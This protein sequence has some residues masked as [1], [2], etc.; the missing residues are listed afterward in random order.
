LCRCEACVEEVRDQVAI[1]PMGEREQLLDDAVRI[2]HEQHQRRRCSALRG[3]F[4]GGAAMVRAYPSRPPAIVVR[5]TQGSKIGRT[6]QFLRRTHGG[7]AALW[8]KF[9]TVTG[10]G[11]G[12]ALGLTGGHSALNQQGA[13]ESDSIIDALVRSAA[14]IRRRNSRC[15]CSNLQH[16]TDIQ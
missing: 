1:A 9:A 12:G 10:R 6:V 11:R 4:R 14:T 16:V 8:E 15:S 13:I 2:A 7:R 3:V 5:P